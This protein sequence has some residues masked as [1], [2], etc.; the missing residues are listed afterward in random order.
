MITQIPKQSCQSFNYIGENS[1]IKLLDTQVAQFGDNLTQCLE[2]V[3]PLA[4]VLQPPLKQPNLEY[5]SELDKLFDPSKMSVDSVVLQ[6]EFHYFV[7]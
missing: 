2:A 7:S 3:K 4:T 6:T 1:R 5:I